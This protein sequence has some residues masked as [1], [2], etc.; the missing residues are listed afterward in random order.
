M[1]SDQSDFPISII[2]PCH[3][4]AGT[5]RATLSSVASQQNAPGKIE[6]IVID[7]A[8]TDES[9]AEVEKFFGEAHVGL[10][11]VVLKNEQNLGVSGTRNR[12]IAAAHGEYIGFLDADDAL[13]PRFAEVLYDAV[14][15]HDADCAVARLRRVS[16]NATVRSAVHEATLRAVTFTGAQYAR[17]A[18]YNELFDTSCGKLYRRQ[19][20]LSHKL[21][22]RGALCFGED[23]LFANSVAIA[24]ERIAVLPEFDGYYYYVD[25]TASLSKRTQI[26][27]RLNDLRTLLEE[28]AVLL[29]VDENRLL[30]RKCCEYL[31]AIRK[32]GGDQRQAM[33]KQAFEC[34][35]GRELLVPTIM[36]YGKRKHRW[37]VALIAL[38]H[39]WLIH[40]W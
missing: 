22:F 7:D 17:E 13:H 21:S 24:S 18:R 3:N 35:F 25:V 37:L 23:T 33:L 36:Q 9:V 10:E 38:K 16:G 4:A 15:T 12:G 11:C 8:S 14:K 20:I 30:L 31:W 1:A 19:F 32:F 27:K 40:F 28:L 29:P 5:I 2:V 26:E 34:P 6:L 39:Y